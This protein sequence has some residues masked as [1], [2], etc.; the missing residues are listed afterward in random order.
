MKNM[1]AHTKKC[2]NV[3]KGWKWANTAKNSNIKQRQKKK[4]N[5]KNEQKQE[6][7]A[8]TGKNRQKVAKT[9]KNYQQ[10]QK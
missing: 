4:K 6:K 3:K 2:K 10:W 9:S 5:A 1:Q 7:I 8:R